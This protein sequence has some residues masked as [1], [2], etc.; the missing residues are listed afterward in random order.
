MAIQLN[1]KITF[2]C[3][4]KEEVR[5][6]ELMLAMKFRKMSELVRHA[7]HELDKTVPDLRP[8][9]VSDKRDS[10][11]KMPLFDR[12]PKSKKKTPPARVAKSKKK[13]A[14]N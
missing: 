4:P 6:T 2:R 8:I 7:L 9:T 11:E 5:W 3:S 13:G 12:K 10:A 14:L 1:R